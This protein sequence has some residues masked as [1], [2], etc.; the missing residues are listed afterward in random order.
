MED[1]IFLQVSLLLGV[2]VSIAFFIRLLRQPLM[3][4]YITAGI[5]CGPMFLNI[6]H[7]G[8]D[9]FE[10]FAQF[11]VVLLLFILGLSL[12]FNYL[13][14][15]GKIALIAGVGQVLFTFII[16]LF[17]LLGLNF[18]LG[19]SLF[20]AIAI[21]FSSTIIIIKLLSD[22]KD[23][24][25]IYG[26]NTI[27]LM[28]VQDVLAILLMLGVGVFKEPSQFT[29]SIL[30]LVIKAVILIGLFVVISKYLL[31]KVLKKI[32][33]SGEFIFIFT[34][35][36]CF[37]VASLV[38]LLGF[39][40]EIG[41]IA[42]GLSLGSSP[43][44]PEIISRIKPLRDF[45]IVIFF[46]ILGS[47][48]NF[49]N[50]N[51]IIVPGLILS[52]FILVGN[53]LILYLIFRFSKFTR[54]NSFLVGLTAAQVSEFG[55]VLLFV[56]QQ[57]G[58]VQSKEISVFTIVALITIFVSSYLITYN[59]KIYDFVSP[60]FRLFKKD[61]H[62][63][64]EPREKTYDVWIFG[65]HRMG[66]KTCKALQKEKINFAVVDINSHTV[67]KIKKMKIP[68]FFGDVADVE[69]LDSLPLHKSKMLILTTPDPHDQK[70]LI[71]F[72]RRESNN[73]IIVSNLHHYKHAEEL[74]EIGADY[75]NMP[76]LLGGQWIEEMVNKKDWG[77]KNTFKKLRKSQIKE[78]KTGF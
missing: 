42:A 46:V 30:F 15:I 19:A 70:T 45:F 57:S 72:I 11:G 8:E 54:R 4:A 58:H 49:T 63:Q 26:R 32:S 77:K 55:F 68:A 51:E 35:T 5:I 47:Q 71:S 78:I 62:R 66:I 28:I 23:T 34:I 36:W 13:K 20:L 43:F 38:H 33:D 22:K 31:P 39:S 10:A 56:G 18:P 17:I 2:T 73:P 48:M 29:S 59:N 67:E 12:N 61:K 53:P 74:Y 65:C 60:F 64:R 37:L 25:T 44:Q 3:V 14:K 40:I 27:G 16:G 76:H 9:T 1:N 41:A 69:F 52:I 7:G 21:T 24:E 75:V 50:F 6:V